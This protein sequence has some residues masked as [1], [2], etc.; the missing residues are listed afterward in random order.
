MTLSC[1]SCP[2]LVFASF[3]LLRYALLRADREALSVDDKEWFEVEAVIVE[4]NAAKVA[5]CGSDD[6]GHPSLSS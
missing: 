5:K 4:G 6:R 1:S 2:L 3:F